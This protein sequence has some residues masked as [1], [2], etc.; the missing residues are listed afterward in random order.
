MPLV[1]AFSLDG[2]ELWFNSADHEPA[3]FHVR[4]PGLWEIR[5]SIL[6][7]TEDELAFRERWPRYGARVSGR[8]QKRLRRLVVRHRVALLAEWEQKVFV[9]EDV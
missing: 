8:L 1:E 4:R 9:R 3:H 2:V 7:T 5:V 6:A